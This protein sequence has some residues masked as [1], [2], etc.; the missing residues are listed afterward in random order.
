MSIPDT[1]TETHQVFRLLLLSP[2]DM[3]NP[4]TLPRIQQLHRL[5]HG[6]NAA[7][8]F[9]LHH[10]EKGTRQ[11]AAMQPFMDLHILLTTHNCPL[12]IIPLL[13]PPEADDTTS[14]PALAAALQTF[15]SSLAATTAA[16]HQSYHWPV[17]AAR[18]LL[19]Y[20]TTT[21]TT[22]ATGRLSAQA[23]EALSRRWVS[24]RELL[25]GI[26]IKEEKEEGVVA[27][28]GFEFPTPPYLGS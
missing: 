21:T 10:D 23:V 12:P 17:D 5:N 25:D 19:P 2:E 3:L 22:N 7:L 11:A 27:F 26:A 16:R 15:Q 4:Q 13:L 24:F 8:V 18:D 9:L 14:A 6:R 28:W 20:T 1:H